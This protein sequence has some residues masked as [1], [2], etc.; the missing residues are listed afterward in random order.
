M[1][2][3]DRDKKVLAVISALVVLGGFWFLVVGKKRSA[4]KEA[5][6]AQLAATKSLEDAKAKEAASRLLAKVKPASY[7]KL[8]R[9]GKAI[10]DNDDFQSLLVQVNDLTDD[11]NVS[12]ISLTSSAQTAAAASTTPDAG[13]TAQT[14][15]CDAGAA[16]A[17]AAATATGSTGAAPT[18]STGGT[19]STAKT[20][21]GKDR[22][23]AKAA[24]AAG[25]ANQAAAANATF[26]CSRAPTLTDLSAQKAGLTPISY[27]LNFKGSFYDLHDVYDRL[28]ALVK[29]H[30]AK[31]KVTGRLLDIN[32]IAMSVTD[33]PML[34]AAVQ[35]TGYRLP[36]EAAA[37]AAT[38]SASA[39]ASA[40]TA[41]ATANGAA[42]GGGTP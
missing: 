15:S 27:S 36:D 14:T 2:M 26:D 11:A 10:P 13:S 31:V 1:G 18:S 40:A 38:A 8:V 17:T 4:I 32:S 21:V 16:G 29:V 41:T 12:F 33:F 24:A 25:N 9:L 37:A 7:A 3:T 22:D 35:M 30:N 23:K 20:W 5:Q 39:A 34:T 6:A 42:S 28:L 19:G